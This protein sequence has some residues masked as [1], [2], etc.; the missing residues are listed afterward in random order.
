MRKNISEHSRIPNNFRSTSVKTGVGADSTK[1]SAASRQG[2]SDFSNLRE[3]DQDLEEST[4]GRYDDSRM[5]MMEDL[6]KHQINVKSFNLNPTGFAQP[7]AK[8]MM[9]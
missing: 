3:V 6:N 5:N 9:V 4:D 1:A 7:G 2:A 8:S